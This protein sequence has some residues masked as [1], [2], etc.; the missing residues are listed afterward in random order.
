MAVAS[1][2]ATLAEL[3]RRIAALEAAGQL[4]NPRRPRRRDCGVAC[5]ECSRQLRRWL[6]ARFAA[7][8]ATLA[9]LP[10]EV[11]GLIAC[12]GGTGAREGGERCDRGGDVQRVS[13]KKVC[14]GELKAEQERERQ[15]KSSQGLARLHAGASLVP[16]E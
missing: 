13:G 4:R 3:A 9:R 11:R 10:D 8:R 2:R 7:R 12:G 1:P 15:I 16:A 5:F 6:A 14:R